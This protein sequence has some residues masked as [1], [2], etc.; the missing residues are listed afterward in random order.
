VYISGRR[1]FMQALLTG[2]ALG[3]LVCVVVVLMVG[4]GEWLGWYLPIGFT[5]EGAALGTLVGVVLLL[6]RMRRRAKGGGD[7]PSKDT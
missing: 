6:F 5:L 2:I 3:C 7:R 4:R 1:I